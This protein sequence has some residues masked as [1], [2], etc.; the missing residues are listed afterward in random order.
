[1]R[2]EKLGNSKFLYDMKLWRKNRFCFCVKH[3]VF[4]VRRMSE[5]NVWS[6]LIK[7]EHRI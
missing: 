7:R 5:F 6:N 1:M 2:F 4:Y 3:V